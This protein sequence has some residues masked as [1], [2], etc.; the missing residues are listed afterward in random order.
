MTKQEDQPPYPIVA[1]GAS[2]GGIKALQTLFAR[3]PSDTGACFVVIVHLDPDRESRLA[4]I[5]G[6]RTDMPAVTVADHVE[7][8]PNCIFVIPPNR[9]L[10]ITDHAIATSEFDAPRGRRTPIDSFFRS[11]AEQRGDGF[12]VVLTGAGAD[13][14]VGVK[15]VKERGGIVLVQDP[16]DAE[17]ASMP[18]SAIATGAADIVLPIPE[19]A[20]QLVALIGSKQKQRDQPALEDEADVLRRVLTHLRAR[21]SHDF[22]H[23]KRSTVMRRILRRMQLA[24]KDTL[25]DYFVFLRENVEEVQA[26]FSDLLISVTTFFRDAHAFDVLAE[27]VIPQLFDDKD[28]SSSVRVWIPGCAT[29][30]EAYSIA[31]L[32]LEEAARRDHHTDVQV[33]ASD[34][35]V[36]A[37]TTAR[38]GS[39]PVT[40]EADI[41][42]ARLRRFFIREG[43][44]YRVKRELRDVVL[45]A[46]HSLLKD[47]PFSRLDLVSCRNL[48]IYL[49]RDLQH[50]VIST[51]NYALVVGGYLFLGASESADNPPGLFRA[52]D[53]DARIYKSVERSSDRILSLPRVTIPPRLPDWPSAAPIAAAIYNEGALHR[54]ALEDFAPPSI[55]IDE[56]HHIVH[57]SESAGRYLLYPGGPPTTEITELVRPELRTD[58][59]SALYRAIEQGQA[60]LS[61]P[62]PVQ[63]NG[64]PERVYVQVRPVTGRDKTRMALVIFIEGGPM[65]TT[66]L[67]D[68][69]RAEVHG[70]N[71][72]IQQLRDELNVTRARLKTSHEEEEAA[73]EE[74]R[75][76]NEELQSINEEYRST[77][78]ELENSKEELQSIN[79]EL[80]TLNN[81]LKLKLESVSRAHNDLQNLMAATDVGTLFLDNRLKI[82]RFTPRVADLFNITANDEGRPITDFTH[83]LN[84]DDLPADAAA[85]LKDLVP[86][87]REVETRAGLWFL[88][89]LRPYRTM[90]DKIDGV[91]VTFVDVTQRRRAE[92]ALRTSETRLQLAREA[93][94]LG[95][96][97]YDP[98]TEAFWWDERARAF[99]GVAPDETVT[100]GLLWSRVHPDDREAARAAFEAALDPRGDG[101]FS[102]EFRLRPDEQG[103]GERWIKTN[104]KAFF[105]GIGPGRR[106]ERLV[107]TVQNT[108]DRKAWEMRQ[109]LLLSELSHRVKNTLAVVQS[110]ARQTFRRTK[111]PKSALA[112]FEG[113]LSALAR[114]HDL[115]V[116]HEWQGAELRALIQSQIGGQEDGG[117]VQLDGPPVML[118]AWL[119]TPFGLLLHELATNASKYGALSSETGTI[120]LSWHLDKSDGKRVLH[121]LWR[122]SGGPKPS[123][124]IKPGFGSYLTEHGVPGAHMTRRFDADGLE[125]TIELPLNGQEDVE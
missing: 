63:F 125:C 74:L 124:S 29:G 69:S 68:E 52:V 107:A 9:Q 54:A 57:L 42:E 114:S 24:R 123:D 66:A 105:A 55:L 79:E 41:S 37:L 30:E 11:F 5:L 121:V 112:A 97:D 32:L 71:L 35:D 18:R 56:A 119:A 26:L 111:N 50:Q 36:A 78:E 67:G 120:R 75:A 48:L 113:R 44:S 47:A 49:D 117:R 51:L 1:I 3:I 94:D 60:S 116:S 46:N 8:S 106:A 17:Y 20:D 34:L 38:E 77:A 64:K 13:G 108:T 115:L 73:N 10:R 6:M 25:S 62:L 72:T 39:Y 19:L 98:D 7:L 82:N 91:V 100:I 59:R 81:E 45:F 110:M 86:I 61:L 31:M 15:A 85:V 118:S 33:F 80:Q 76:A 58:L 23:Y 101:I 70:I 92:E 104:G 43:Q 65:D 93:S 84:Y 53:R 27:Q 88:M 90:D 99:W 28:T 21:T 4:E 122:E 89:R 2:A 109:R 96:Y 16:L 103:E 14:S 83:R 40:I 87:E 12:A 22:S 102:A 95:I